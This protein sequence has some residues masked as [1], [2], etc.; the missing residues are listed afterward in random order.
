MTNDE[1]KKLLWLWSDMVSRCSNSKHKAFK[2]YG[3]R[4]IRVCERWMTFQNF[5]TDMAPRPAGHML[6][7]KNNDG[8]YEPSNCRWATRKEQNSN[9]RNCIY[10]DCDGERVTLKECCR[11]KA[12]TYRPV[13]KRIQTLGWSVSDAISIPI[14]QRRSA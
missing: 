13:V 10:V 6:D 7:R 11:R 3:G 14:G 2:N 4:G 9:R 1:K 5:L 12:L 8:D